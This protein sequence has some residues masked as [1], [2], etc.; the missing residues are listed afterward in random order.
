MTCPD[1][2]AALLPVEGEL[3]CL[4]CGQVY[5]V[6]NMSQEKVSPKDSSSGA[7]AQAAAVEPVPQ[8]DSQSFWKRL[9]HSKRS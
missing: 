4:Q 8:L 9:W 2:R 5:L 3:F 1:C 6:S 7:Q